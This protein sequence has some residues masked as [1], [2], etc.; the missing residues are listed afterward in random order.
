MKDRVGRDIRNL[1]WFPA[2]AEI[3][4]PPGMLFKVKGTT[5]LGNGLT[6]VQMQHLGVEDPIVDLVAEA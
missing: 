6:M 5:D 3:L 2:E 1:S 4:L